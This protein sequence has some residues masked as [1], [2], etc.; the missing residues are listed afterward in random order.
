MTPSEILAPRGQIRAPMAYIM[1]ARVRGQAERRALP[2]GGN[3]LIQIPT[4][5]RTHQ[6]LS[7]NYIRKHVIFNQSSLTWTLEEYPTTLSHSHFWLQD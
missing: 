5:L 7:K 2:N 6:P 4:E 1:G 3:I